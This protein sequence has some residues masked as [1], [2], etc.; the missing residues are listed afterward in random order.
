MAAI[1][2]RAKL[3]IWPFGCKVLKRSSE[4]TV[5]QPVS[6]LGAR[7]RMKNAASNTRR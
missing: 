5:A 3:S 2:H 7:T 4:L 6:P 1:W